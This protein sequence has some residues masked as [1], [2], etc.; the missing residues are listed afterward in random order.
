MGSHD[1]TDMQRV[2]SFH[3]QFC[4]GGRTSAKEGSSAKFEL[5][6]RCAL[7]SQSSLVSYKKTKDQ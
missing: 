5:I 1:G 2:H 4:V 3:W 6:S 7:A